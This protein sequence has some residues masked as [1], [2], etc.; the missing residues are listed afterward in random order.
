M[1]KEE[2]LNELHKRGYDAFV[3]END[4]IILNDGFKS[5]IP[6]NSTYELLNPKEDIIPPLPSSEVVNIIIANHDIKKEIHNGE[7]DDYEGMS[8]GELTESLINFFNQIKD[9]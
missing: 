6:L 9:E 2:I 3:I 4:I 1:T 7:Y 8:K 5:T